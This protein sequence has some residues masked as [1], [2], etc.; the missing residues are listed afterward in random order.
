[1]CHDGDDGVVIRSL[2]LIGLERL[3][4]CKSRCV[5]LARDVVV[6]MQYMRQ[7][8]CYVYTMCILGSILC[9]LGTYVGMYM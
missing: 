3:L 1:M 2:G 5:S 7:C 8:V 6:D 9:M 4:V